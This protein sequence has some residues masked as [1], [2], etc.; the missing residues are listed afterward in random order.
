MVEYDEFRDNLSEELGNLTADTSDDHYQPIHDVVE[1]ILSLAER[2][3]ESADVVLGDVAAMLR[4][5]SSW[6]GPEEC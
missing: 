6:T 1:G 2:H 5:V 3:D 4:R